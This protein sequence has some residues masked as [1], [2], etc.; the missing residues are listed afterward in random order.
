MALRMNAFSSVVEDKEHDCYYILHRIAVTDDQWKNYYDA[1]CT[2]N[3]NAF[4]NDKAAAAEI[5]Y[6]GAFK[7]LEFR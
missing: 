7:N 3:F 1:K 4:M 6:K 2:A 5:V